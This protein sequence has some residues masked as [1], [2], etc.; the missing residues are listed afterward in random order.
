[1][2]VSSSVWTPIIREG[3]GTHARRAIAG[4]AGAAFATAILAS[5]LSPTVWRAGCPVERARYRMIHDDRFSAGFYPIKKYDMW[6]DLAFFV[7]SKSTAR[8]FWFLFTSGSSE[9]LTLVSTTDVRDKTWSP[10]DPDGGL[11][12][13]GD[14]QVMF[15]ASRYVFI[16]T[17]P[18]RKSLRPEYVLLPDLP[19]ALAN[20]AKPPESAPLDFFK[21]DHCAAPGAPD[22]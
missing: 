7:R 12:P 20:R 19:D 14:T 11:R 6:P 4:P 13:L 16:V 2:A 22:F 10:P 17:V 5:L 9:Y 3:P 21:F 15:A 8:T 18:E 1:M